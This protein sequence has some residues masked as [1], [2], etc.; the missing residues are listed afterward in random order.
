MRSSCEEARGVHDGEMKPEEFGCDAVDGELSLALIGLKSPDLPRHGCLLLFVSLFFGTRFVPI[1]YR[2][3]HP[4]PFAHHPQ[5][6][7]TGSVRRHVNIK[8]NGIQDG[9]H[10]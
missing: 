2:R 3:Q 5:I 9:S 8:Y 10:G 7:A 1:T 6:Q 4:V